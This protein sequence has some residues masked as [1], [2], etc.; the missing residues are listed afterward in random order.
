[1]SNTEHYQAELPAI[2]AIPVA[3]L[4]R[5]VMPVR[6]Y[7]YEAECLY[8]WSQVDRPLLAKAGL[9]LALLDAIPQRAG[10]LSE[11]E[12][13]WGVERFA[14]E[15]ARRAW[16]EQSPAAYE[17]RDRLL[18]DM[19]F[20]FRRDD[21]LLARVA[22]IADGNGHVDMLQDLNDLAVLGRSQLPALAVIGLD[23]AVLEQAA[24]LADDL[25]TLLAQVAGERREG[26]TTLQLRDQAYTHLKAAVDE[27]R[28]H[29]QYV[30]WNNPARRDG[31]FSEYV[32][33][34]NARAARRARQEAGA[35][36]S[37]PVSV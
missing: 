17:L 29:G 32:R 21:A 31:Y 28:D 25:T 13:Y 14:H 4:K 24:T 12:S 5:P 11:I 22:A 26:S 37:E 36:A 27:V 30:F 2:Q 35:Q 20:A 6:Q 1:M 23:A 18:R 34:A 3:S 33:A 8:Q 9:D 10:A 15:D 7:V 19:R 16:E